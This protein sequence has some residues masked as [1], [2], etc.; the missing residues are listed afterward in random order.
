[1]AKFTTEL[2]GDTLAV[3]S[4]TRLNGDDEPQLCGIASVDKRVA[5]TG[6]AFIKT[7]MEI[8]PGCEPDEIKEVQKMLLDYITRKLEE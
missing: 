5:S 4:A 2:W 6:H 3:Q 1:M 7:T 8:R